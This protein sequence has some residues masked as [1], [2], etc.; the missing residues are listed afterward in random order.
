[1]ADKED[2][3][4]NEKI[5]HPRDVDAFWMQRKLSKYYDDPTMAQ[6]KATEVLEVLRVRIFACYVKHQNSY[7][8]IKQ[9]FCRQSCST[10]M[11][12]GYLRLH[13]TTS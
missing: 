1:L 4:K 3:G 13:V 7:C 5:L 12:L 11:L 10:G 6:T 9:S 8:K 2:S